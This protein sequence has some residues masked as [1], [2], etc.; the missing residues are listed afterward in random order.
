MHICA[1]EA[2]ESHINNNFSNDTCESEWFLNVQQPIPTV[3]PTFF[4]FALNMQSEIDD[5]LVEKTSS[6]N[7]RSID[8]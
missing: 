1:S 2:S 7:Y 8:P 5:T 3:S 4:F 6:A